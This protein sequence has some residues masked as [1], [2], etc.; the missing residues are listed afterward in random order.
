[1]GISLV[2]INLPGRLLGTK[3]MCDA[4]RIL[5]VDDEESFLSVLGDAL[6]DF[7]YEVTLAEDGGVAR[8]LVDSERFD[9]IISDVFM[10]LVDGLELH[11][12]IREGAQT[13]DVPFIFLSGYDYGRGEGPV[14]DPRRDFILSKTSSLEAIVAC[15]ELARAA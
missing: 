5:L 1:L 10:P 6:R 14:H 7:G 4:M 9:L 12:H 3:V 15:I 13:R 8:D 11:R 2:P